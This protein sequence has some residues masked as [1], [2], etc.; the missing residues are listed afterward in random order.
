MGFLIAGAAVIGAFKMAAALAVIVPIL[1]LGVPLFD[2]AFAVARRA[3]SG[4]PIYMPDRGH[5]HHRLLDAGLT[6]NQAVLVI[7]AATFLLS[8]GALAVVLAVR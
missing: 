3:A 4:R 7:Y 8:A 6:V 2:A 5:L 1:A